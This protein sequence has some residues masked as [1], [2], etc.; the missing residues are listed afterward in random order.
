MAQHFPRRAQLAELWHSAEP[1]LEVPVLGLNADYR[2]RPLRAPEPPGSPATADALPPG[3]LPGRVPAHG[4]GLG[5]AQRR[6]PPV[7]AGGLGHLAAAAL[8]RIHKD[9]EHL[10]HRF[11]IAED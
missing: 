6:L 8:Q 9:T 11:W 3:A 5:L 4:A 2:V 1:H 7:R 10:L